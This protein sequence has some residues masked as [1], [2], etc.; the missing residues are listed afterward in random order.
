MTATHVM[1]SAMSA[2]QSSRLTLSSVA[3]RWIAANV[4]PPAL[5][6][7]AGWA[8]LGVSGVSLAGWI[9][10]GADPPRL[11]WVAIGM[12]ALYLVASIWLR[13]AVLRPLVPR[14]TI[15]GWV[16]AALFTGAVMLALTTAG[17]FVGLAVAKG[18]AMTD[19]AAP[20][21]PTGL[22]LIPFVIGIILG[23]EILGLFL[24]GLPGLLISAGEALVVGRARRSVWSWMLWAALGW[25]TVLTLIMLHAFLV[26]FDRS[27]PSG[28]LNVLT[29]AAPIIVGLAAALTSLPAVARLVRRQ[30]GVG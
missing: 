21:V 30:N 8:Y 1:K 29:V 5:L 12:G 3:P 24:G 9:N 16:P 7:A 15:L 26:V 10:G 19:A 23:T 4:L 2:T 22:K 28:V 17:A 13:G 14:F 20:A 25:S 11:V 18:L 6:V 27:V